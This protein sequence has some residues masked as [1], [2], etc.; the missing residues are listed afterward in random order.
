MSKD[1]CPWDYHKKGD[2]LSPGGQ[3]HGANARGG[4]TS[5]PGE[6]TRPKRR[7][8]PSAWPNIG[9]EEGCRG[10]VGACDDLRR[11]DGGG[12]PEARKVHHGRGEV[13]LGSAAP[14]SA[15]QCRAAPI[16]TKQRHI[17]A[18]AGR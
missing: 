10:L 13:E 18:E 15:Q 16:S 8:R 17:F 6:S 9:G 3:T 2:I 14:S 7:L 4:E 1:T 5:G 11:A 12:G